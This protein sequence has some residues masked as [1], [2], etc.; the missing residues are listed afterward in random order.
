MFENCKVFTACIIISCWLSCCTSP[1][2][3]KNTDSFDDDNDL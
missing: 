3:P 2:F 1:K